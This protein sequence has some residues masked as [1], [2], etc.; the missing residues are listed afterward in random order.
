LYF[1][2]ENDL[3]NIFNKIKTQALDLTNNYE[4]KDDKILA[5][6]SWITKN[7]K[8]DNLST[9]FIENKITEKYY[10]SKVDNNVFT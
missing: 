5:L 4:K 8:Y 1:Y 6:Y 10:L 9:N 3:D 2:K 7:I